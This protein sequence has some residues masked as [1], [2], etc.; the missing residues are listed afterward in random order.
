MANKN[1]DLLKTGIRNIPVEKGFNA[2][3]YHFGYSLDKKDVSKIAKQYVKKNYSKKDATAILAN[4]EWNFTAYTG[5]IA[6]AYCM[7]NNID[8]PDPY[9]NYPTEVNQYFKGLIAKGNG[10]LRS[11][12]VLE[13]AKVE[14]KVY[15]P[16]QRLAM[17]INDTVMRDIDTLE[18]EWYE[19]QKTDLDI[20]AKMRIH[21]LKG[22]AVNPVVEYLKRM[23]P[24][25]ED[26][27]S[28]ACKDAK[29]AYAHLGKR[30]LT[31]RIKVINNMINDLLKWKEDQKTRRKRK[32]A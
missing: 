13:E 8:I 12:A 15:T 2:V 19:G 17:K 10:V 32:T 4:A 5:L 24:E 6:A 16:Q 14:K 28:G 3:H 23:L 30:E 31:R 27:H 29:A 22:M 1:K 7:D 11:K 26:A 25:Y 9:A 20:V 21:E 18:D